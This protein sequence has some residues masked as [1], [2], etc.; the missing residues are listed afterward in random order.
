MQLGCE[1]RG[2][3]APMLASQPSV[4]E[5]AYALGIDKS[6]AWQVHRIATASDPVAILTALP[7]H[8]GMRKAIGAIR[9]AGHDIDG[10]ERSRADLVHVLRRRGISRTQLRSMALG[11]S[12]GPRSAGG[13][14][15]LHRRAH[16][17]TVAMRGMSIG[18]AAIA[19]M[20]APGGAT[21]QI[22]LVAVTLLHRIGR[23]VN[24]GPIP[25]Y[26]RTQAAGISGLSEKTGS[27]RRSYAGLVL[28]LCSQEVHEDHIRTREYG[29]SEVLLYDPP[30]SATDRVDLA[31]REIGHGV[32][33]VR[34]DRRHPE[35]ASGIALYYPVEH[36][37]IDLMLHN[38]LQARDPEV[39]L[40][41][42]SAP[43]AVCDANPEFLRQPIP[44]ESRWTED[45][46]LPGAFAA[47]GGKWQRLIE[48]SAR[49]VGL[50][51]K[52]FRRFRTHIECP[53]TPSRVHVRWKWQDPETSHA[54][55]AP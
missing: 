44:I 29:T 31:F 19:I 24:A 23:T 2:C 36:T 28:E 32:A 45:D 8:A 3:I 33:A 54:T 39:A 22:T 55:I 49:N 41:L 42:L 48:D 9:D 7:G 46:A 6:L 10:L 37:V 21:R 38:S 51:P 16:E 43:M 14:R 25:V 53:P 52:E 18:G 34:G 26:F 11:G 40:Y 35:A 1:L 27:G 15:H 30:S 4:R 5:F 17:A 13:L 47:A 20:L 12:D 50:S